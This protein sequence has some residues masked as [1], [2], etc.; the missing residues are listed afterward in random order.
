MT[1]N[2]ERVIQLLQKENPLLAKVLFRV[3]S[4]AKVS[5]HKNRRKKSFYEKIR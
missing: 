4:E 1:K 3:E 5:S 2:K